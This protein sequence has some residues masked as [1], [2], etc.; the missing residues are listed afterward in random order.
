MMTPVQ[1]IELIGTQQ[2]QDAMLKAL[3]DVGVV[4]IRDARTVIT[5]TPSSKIDYEIAQTKFAL[6]FL[7]R[8]KPKEKFSLA[9]IV[10]EEIEISREKLEKMKWEEPHKNIVARVEVLEKE[11]NRLTSSIDT[12]QEKNDILEKWK[13]ISFDLGTKLTHVDTV[14]VETNQDGI[15]SLITYAHEK[16]IAIDI[17]KKEADGTHYVLLYFTQKAQPTIDETLAQ[18]NISRVTIPYIKGQTITQTLIENKQEIVKAEQ[19]RN[20]VI[21]DIID[22]TSHTE[23]LK[24]AYDYLHWQKERAAAEAK[25]EKSEYVFKLHG[26]T[27]AN[28]I[29]DIENALESITSEFVLNTI[30]KDED[31]IV[32]VVLTNSKG[33]TPFETVTAIYGAPQPHD[34]DPTP[35]MAPFFIFFF[36]L[37]LTD[38]GYGLILAAL[39]YALIKVFKL[40]PEQQ[41]LPRVL[42]FGGIITFFAGA[43]FGSWFGIDLSILPEPIGSTLKSLQIMDPI[44]N[45]MPTLILSAVLGVVQIISA[46]I[47]KLVY[48]IRNG[49]RNDALLGELPWLIFFLAVL[50]NLGGGLYA[51]LAAYSTVTMYFLYASLAG[52]ILTQGRE[53]KNVFMKLGGGIL[54]LYDIVGYISDIIS[55]SRI[56]ALG[57]VTGII[58]MV[59]NIIAGLFAE[60]IPYVGWLVA[61][62]ILIAGHTF[63]LAINALSAFIHSGRLQFVEFFSKLIEGGGTWLKPL[64]KESQ[65]IKVVD[66]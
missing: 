45:P 39:S 23:T 13:S 38:A 10:P 49:Q 27:P 3:Q 7:S 16:E 58:A 12:L 35:Y 4:E 52:L 36:G 55:Y 43:L 1:K 56:F 53:H 19:H 28:K 20:Q 42:M 5:E 41:K 57:L 33:I 46:F 22:T 11:L 26:W 66:D 47:F 51:P 54:S 2:H 14:A 15:E 29:P 25:L 24:I 60:M 44:N 31:E 61:L 6:N 8:Y 32:P 40:K 37:C 34:M 59:V 48:K 64:R 9:S 18:P 63:N 50:L 65:Y 30:E 62:I 17:V 21:D